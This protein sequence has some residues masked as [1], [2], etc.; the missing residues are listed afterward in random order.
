N[1]SEL[2]NIVTGK[3]HLA[4]PSNLTGSKFKNKQ[5]KLT[6]RDNST[7]ETAFY[8]YS[9]RDGINWTKVAIVS[10][11]SGTGGTDSWPSGTLASGLW[12]FKVTATDANGES[13]PSNIFSITL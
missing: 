8:V 9:S 7:T 6:W 5:V 13:D 4:A 3:T 2:S 11:L 10:P 1:V 12:Y